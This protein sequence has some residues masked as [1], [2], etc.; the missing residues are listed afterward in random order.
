MRN[1]IFYKTTADFDNTGEVLIYKSLLNFLRHYG[2]VVINDG[3]SIQPKFLQRLDVTEQERLSGKT[4]EGFMGYLLRSA[5][6]S[7]FCKERVYF[8]TGVGE[9]NVAG[10][11]SVVKNALSFCFLALFRLLGG[12]VLRIGM[13]MRFGGRMEQLSEKLLSYAVNHYYVRDSISLRNCKDAGVSRCEM[14]PD[15]S[16]GYKIDFKEF[17]NREDIYMSFRSYCEG[18]TKAAQYEARLRKVLCHLVRGISANVNGY[19]VFSWQCDEDYMFMKSLYDELSDVANLKMGEELITLDNA[20]LYYGKAKYILSNRLHVLLLGYK[21]GAPTICISDIE[22][23]RK[24]RGVFT[25]NGL[26]NVLLDMNIPEE[27]LCTHLYEITKDTSYLEGNIRN[28]ENRNRQTLENLF[29]NIF[30]S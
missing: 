18:Q 19:I 27:D 15:L 25:D 12:R 17:G 3:A 4:S 26:Q 20:H 21:F 6:M 22:R 28:A 13:S 2:E 10:V 11:K 7:L 9:H 1:L 16:W 5:F 8:V 24:I 14:A 23:H 30:D 29:K